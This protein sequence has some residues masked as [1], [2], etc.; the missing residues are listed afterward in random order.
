MSDTDVFEV[1]LSMLSGQIPS[2][3]AYL[4][5]IVLAIVFW[6]RYPRPALLVMMGSALHLLT[7]LLWV[8]IYAVIM[9]QGRGIGSRSLMF[10]VLSLSG[11]VI[12]AAATVLIICA[13]FVGRRRNDTGLVGFPMAT[14][15]QANPPA[16]AAPTYR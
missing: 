13:A 1:A 12:H 5:G 16:A 10:T 4:T 11:S 8:V 3:L 6:R 9:E 14:P 7:S 15:M 2:L